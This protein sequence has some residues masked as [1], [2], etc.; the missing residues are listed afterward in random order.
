MAA[1]NA[2]WNRPDVFRRVVSF[3]GSYTGLRGGDTLATLIR[4]T[5]PKPIRIFMQDGRADLDIYSGSWFIGNQQIYSALQFAGYEST[6]VIGAEGHNSK[7]GAAILPDALR[8]V[9]K[10]YPKPIAKPE[11]VNDRSVSDIVEF[12]KDWEFVGGGYQLTADSTVDKDGNVF[13]T[14]HRKNRIGKVDEIGRAH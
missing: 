1:F 14:D 4:K 13:F 2:A 11:K 3:I 7:H 8:W 10:D 12:G 6:L 9:W 5:E